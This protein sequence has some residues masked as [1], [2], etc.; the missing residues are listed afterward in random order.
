MWN[1][2]FQFIF[3]IMEQQ[4]NGLLVV[5]LVIKARHN[6]QSILKW[7]LL[8]QLMKN[9]PYYTVALASGELDTEPV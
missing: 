3:L 6:V 1:Q 2:M 9:K 7:D 8:G 5:N 4:C